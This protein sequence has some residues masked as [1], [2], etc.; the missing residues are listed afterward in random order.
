MSEPEDGDARPTHVTET[1]VAAGAIMPGAFVAPAATRM[2]WSADCAVTELYSL[3]YRPLV[4]LAALL[5]RDTPTAEEVVQDAFVAMHGGWQR[6]R[7]AEN[8]LAYLRQA[9]VNRSRSVLRHRTVVDKNLQKA[10][11]DMPSAEHGALAQLERSAV[12]DALRKLPQ[13]QR[14]AIVLRYY[15]DF[16]EAEIATAMKHQPW[17]GQESYR[18]WNGRAAR[19]AGAGVMVRLGRGFDGGQGQDFA[20]FLRRE[21]HAAADQVEPGSDGLERI[22]DKIRSRPAHA[23]QPNWILGVWLGVSGVAARLIRR[24]GFRVRRGGPRPG[25]QRREPRRPRDWRE[26]M[27]RPAFAVGAAVFAVG[28][29]LSVVPPA[30]QGVVQVS[31][32]IGSALNISSSSSGRR[33]H[34]GPGHDLSGALGAGSVAVQ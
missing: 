16:S 4:R 2:G 11:P 8:A 24:L 28:V 27:L 23:S 17:R 12:V 20:D 5:V 21:L 14:E 22:R 25:P 30:R 26:A 29:V 7:D 33:H 31:D 32:A 6:L 1:L 34:G 3:H 13:R 18:A 15:A 19:G 10:P 9:V